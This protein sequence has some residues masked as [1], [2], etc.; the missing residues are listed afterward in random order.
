MIMIP[1][2]SPLKFNQI[3]IQINTNYHIMITYN[4]NV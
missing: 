3:P 1:S 4:D 2:Y